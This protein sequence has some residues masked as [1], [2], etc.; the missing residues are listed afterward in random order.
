MEGGREVGLEGGMEGV[1]RWG[2]RLAVSV[3]PDAY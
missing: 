1:S 2:F 3:S